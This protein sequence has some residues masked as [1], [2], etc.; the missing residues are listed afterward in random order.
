MLSPGARLIRFAPQAGVSW[1][2]MLPRRNCC[3]A[4]QVVPPV[5]RIVTE[6]VKDWPSGTVV[7]NICATNT[8]SDGAGG[9]SF[10]VTTTLLVDCPNQ[11]SPSCNMRHWKL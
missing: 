7:G 5:L 9:A 1:G 3:A 10:T 8:A 6:A 11:N 4:V 2:L